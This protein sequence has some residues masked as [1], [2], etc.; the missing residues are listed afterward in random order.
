MMFI[1]VKAF[2]RSNLDSNTCF[3]GGKRD[4]NKKDDCDQ[5][6]KNKNKERL[7]SRLVT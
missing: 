7:N 1:V 6:S 5:R 4:Y 3:Y 2:K